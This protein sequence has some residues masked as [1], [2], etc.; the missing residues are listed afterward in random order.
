MPAGEARGEMPAGRGLGTCA[1]PSCPSSTA[2]QHALGLE[3][4][5]LCQVH[6]APAESHEADGCPSPLEGG[7]EVAS[8]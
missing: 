8:T 5:A 7:L 1:C 4:F 6:E 3:V 2:S